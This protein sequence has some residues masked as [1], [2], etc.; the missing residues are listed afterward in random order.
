MKIEGV[1]DPPSVDFG[2]VPLETSK[3]VP[4]QLKNTGNGAFE[5]GELTITEGFILKGSKAGFKGERLDPGMSM[6]LEVEFFAM[7]EGP[8]EGNASLALSGDQTAELS[9]KANGRLIRLPQLTATP[10]ALDFG[11]VEIGSEQRAVVTLANSGNAPGTVVSSMLENGST[12]FSVDTSSFPLTIPEGENATIE[13]AFRPMTEGVKTEQVLL[14][15]A[16]NVDGPGI[17]LTGQGRKPLGEIL[18]EPTRIDFGQLERGQVE[19]RSVQC[20][21]RGGDAEVVGARIEGPPD[22]FRLTNSVMSQSLADGEMIQIDVDFTSEGLPV[23]H[24]GRLLVEFN[25]TD[26]PGTAQVQL[27]AEVVPPPPTETAI[28]LVLSW[29][30]NFTDIDLHF[31]R[32]TGNSNPRSALFQTDS[33]C[34][35]ANRTPDWNN[36]GPTDDPFLDQDDTNGYGPETINLNQTQP[37]MYDV[38]VHYY[39][40]NFFG[41]SRA[42]VE[43]HLSGQLVGTFDQVVR[44]DQ[45][46]HVGTIDW[47]GMAGTFSPSTDVQSSSEGACF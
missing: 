4:V 39:A 1:F 46:W 30:T 35:F 15:L 38:F 18:C 41:P 43:V 36:P 13:L 5:I 27:S 32:P 26:G 7:M 16:E 9:L 33:D 24:S 22:V 14:A 12:E 44:C 34:Y 19:T 11:A 40:D 31:V 29:D 17:Q 2:D 25:G 42:T 45:I 21:A 10:A 20:A 28:S 6:D 3:A 37:G 47:D 8:R 23:M